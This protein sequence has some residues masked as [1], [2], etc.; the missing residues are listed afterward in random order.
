MNERKK[1]ERKKERM[2]ECKKERKKEGRIGC[3]ISLC[4]SLHNR[5]DGGQEM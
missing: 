5:N 4:F 2:F 3:V 1:E